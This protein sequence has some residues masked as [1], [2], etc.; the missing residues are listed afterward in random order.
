MQT[1]RFSS[2]V[3]KNVI[4]GM[5]SSSSSPIITASSTKDKFVLNPKAMAFMGVS[6]E[7][8]VVM[9]DRNKGE[10]VTQDSNAR[11]L[12]TP[13]WERN[14]GYYEGAKIGKGGTFSYAG[15]YSAIQLN[16]PAITE[17]SAKDL[18]EAD[19]AIFR[20]T[21]KGNQACIAKQKVA[22]KLERLAE[23]DEESGEVQETF[24]VAPGIFQAVYCMTD[25]EV[26]PHD[27]READEDD[28]APEGEG[29]GNSAALVE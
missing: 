27:P 18:V 21:G 12:I 13:G 11:W 5:K 16:D 6:P 2:F 22:F 29:D 8:Y 25:L 4:S 28:A 1:S 9:I 17:G 3:G 19:K 15:I 20:E 26:I 14:K 23:K 7:S 10:V 24:E